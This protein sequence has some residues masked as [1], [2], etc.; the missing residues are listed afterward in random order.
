M[1]M[2]IID[3]HTITLFQLFNATTNKPNAFNNVSQ[4]ILGEN[5]IYCQGTF[6]KVDLFNLMGR[7]GRTFPP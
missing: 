1:L 7:L 3:L 4:Y 2:T 6:F 5:Y